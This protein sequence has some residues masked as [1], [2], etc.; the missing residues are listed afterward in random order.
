[1]CLPGPSGP[2]AALASVDPK[3]GA[4]VALASSSRLLRP[5]NQFNLAAQAH[6]QPGSSFKPYVLTTAIK[7]GIDPETT[8]YNGTSPEDLTSVCN[9]GTW[10]PHNAEAGGGTMNLVR[11]RSSP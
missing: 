9:C 6:R 4:I 11:R 1:M 2:T 10:T 5:T 8:Y 7:Q 3:T